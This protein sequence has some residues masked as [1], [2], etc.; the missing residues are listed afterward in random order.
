M[1]FSIRQNQVAAHKTEGLENPE[2]PGN[3][4]E[5]AIFRTEGRSFFHTSHT[6][7]AFGEYWDV[8]E[9]KKISKKHWTPEMKACCAQKTKEAPGPPFFFKITAVGW[10]F[11][12]ACFGFLGYLI[13]DWNKAPLPKS[14]DVIA[15]EQPLAEGDI[16]FG[17]FEQYKESEQ[18][19][20]ISD[21]VGHGWFKIVK[22]EG[23]TC[24]VAKSTEMSKTHQ[25]KEELDNSNFETES[26]P[27]N[28]KE[29][30]SYTVRLVSTDG[31]TEFYLN[32]KKAE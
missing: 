23:D 16:F 8:T 11:L 10:L 32:E 4:M 24:H 5:L 14:E 1:F 29:K 9:G 21:G 2:N 20:R 19:G 31:N 7:Q 18:L 12:L 3:D 27:A 13:Y 26:T 22:V 17:H 25:A 6:K 30:D 15:M 28:V